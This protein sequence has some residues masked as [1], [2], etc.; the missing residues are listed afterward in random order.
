MDLKL[1]NVSEIFVEVHSKD[2]SIMSQKWGS[3]N[4][5]LIN[6]NGK[7]GISLAYVYKVST[8]IIFQI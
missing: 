6:N 7:D 4:L 8:S 2:E 3:D 5:Y 1:A